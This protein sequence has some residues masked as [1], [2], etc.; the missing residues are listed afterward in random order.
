MAGA[1][2]AYATGALAPLVGAD[3]SISACVKSNAEGNVRVVAPGSACKSNEDR[4]Q[5]N[6]TGPKGDKGDTGGAGADGED[7]RSLVGTPIAGGEARC[8]GNGGIAVSYDDGSAVGDLCNGAAGKDGANGKD[9]ADGNDGA[10][11]PASLAALEGTACALPGGAGGTV[12]VTVG[13][14]GAVS[15]QCAG[16]TPPAGDDADG[17]GILDAADNC[18]AVSNA[19]QADSD[20]DGI[21]NACDPT[22]NGDPGHPEI[23]NGIDDDLDGVV[24]DNLTDRPTVPH[25]VVACTAGA[26]RI[27][28]CSAGFADVN[29]VFADGCEVDLGTDLDNCGAIGNHPPVGVHATFACVAGTLRVASCDAGFYDMDGIVADGCEAQGDAFEPNETVGTARS[30]FG[31]L[32]NAT[33][34]PNGDTDAFRI[35]VGAFSSVSASLSGGVHMDVF[36]DGSLDAA[37]VTTY[38]DTTIFSSATYTFVVRQNAPGLTAPLPYTLHF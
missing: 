14:S 18:P 22:P 24:D 3:G 32:V 29:H 34:A 2:V 36:K 26:Y 23:C 11:G 17:D 25:A 13:S 33:I 5:W 21:G 10:A 7:G 30:V 28:Q 15:I 8:G 4:L 16:G 19:D 20:N 27:Q 6:Q 37:N 35:T 9:G 12:H 31:G 1:G 38:S